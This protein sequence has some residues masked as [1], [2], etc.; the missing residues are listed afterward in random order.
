MKRLF[1]SQPMRGKTEDEI[2]RERNQLRE[3]LPS[4]LKEDVEIMDTFF[5]DEG[6]PLELLGRSLEMLANADAAYFLSG[7]EQARGCRIEH[8]A[9]VEYGIE[10]I[11]EEK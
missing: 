1:V 11:G 3:C 9:T 7:W 5:K 4:I 10:I 8:E 2:A 6:K